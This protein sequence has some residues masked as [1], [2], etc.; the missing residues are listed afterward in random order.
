MSHSDW[1]RHSDPAAAV[2]GLLDAAGVAFARL[3]V[4]R[5]T[6]IDVARQAGCS[7]ATLYRYFPNREALRLGFVHRATLRI[8]AEIAPPTTTSDPD[9]MVDLIMRGIAAVRADPLLSVWFEPEN[10]AVPIAVS[11][12]SELLQAM[13]AGLAE[14]LASDR[15]SSADV[16]LRGAWLLRSIV[17]FLAMPAD[18]EATERAMVEAFVVP[19]LVPTPDRDRSRS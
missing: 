15:Q 19:L 6:M 14:Q 2:D 18:S 8:A 1:S 13:T 9:E 4:A 10:M 17:S 11:Q 7:R 3:G 5:A 12:D 16:E